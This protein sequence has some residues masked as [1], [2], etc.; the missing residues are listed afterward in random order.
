M[1][2]VSREEAIGKGLKRFY[3]GVACIH[4]HFDER[5]VSD[6]QGRACVACRKISNKSRQI[7]YKNSDLELYLSRVR[8]RHLKHL[9]GMK[10]GAERVMLEKQ[11][12]VCACCGAPPKQ[13]R[14]NVDH[15]HTSGRVRSLLCNRCNTAISVL[16]DA[17]LAVWTAYLEAHRTPQGDVVQEYDGFADAYR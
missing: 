14:L 16:E 7:K 1:N 11:G 12:G 5:Y 13:K 8:E 9:Y 17:K 6:N 10:A 4:G 15:C 3:T 2:I